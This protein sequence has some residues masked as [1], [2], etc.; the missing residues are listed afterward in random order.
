MKSAT[1]QNLWVEYPNVFNWD[2]VSELLPEMVINS[3]GYKRG[4]N[5]E[6]EKIN[7]INDLEQ[8]FLNGYNK[9]ISE[10]KNG[11]YTFTLINLQDAITAILGRL[12]EILEVSSD[13]DAYKY[14]VSACA[15]RE[16]YEIRQSISYDLMKNIQC[17]YFIDGN[18]ISETYIA[19]VLIEV[20][21]VLNSKEY[22]LF[23]LYHIKG[24]T[25]IEVSETM[26][27]SKSK[28][29]RQ[30]EVIANKIDNLKIA[31]LYDNKYVNHNSGKKKRQHKRSQLSMAEIKDLAGIS[32]KVA[33]EDYEPMTFKPVYPSKEQANYFPTK[34]YYKTSR[35]DFGYINEGESDYFFTSN[36]VM[37]HCK[38]SAHKNT[39]EFLEDYKL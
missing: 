22:R 39:N 23:S 16:K 7:N 6:V 10:I 35:N 28:I 34:Q 1:C 8:S 24:Y 25:L 20:K 9:L 12:N 5:G 17:E 38:V 21:R 37:G 31:Y 27:E 15:R 2:K 36:L 18:G 32:H 19:E 11:R 33:I 14:L 4:E 29:H 13:S 3:N 30:L 26:K